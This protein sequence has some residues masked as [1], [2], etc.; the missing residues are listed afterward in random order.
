MGG[1]KIGEYMS[2]KMVAFDII[3]ERL[4]GNRLAISLNAF[5]KQCLRITEAA[6]ELCGGGEGEMKQVVKDENLTVTIWSGTYANGGDARGGGDTRCNF[7]WHSLKDESDGPSGLQDGCVCHEC[8]N[9]GHR[10]AL[11]AIAAHTVQRLRSESNVA[12]DGD[13][14]KGEFFH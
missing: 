3:R 11:Y 10:S 14:S 7:A 5:A 2:R 1:L 13:L 9:G 6:N 4:A 12:Y 8:S